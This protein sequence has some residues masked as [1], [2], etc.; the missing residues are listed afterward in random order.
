MI[1]I[2]V[3]LEVISTTSMNAFAA[4]I[5]S[6]GIATV[7]CFFLHTKDAFQ[8]KFLF[9]QGTLVEFGK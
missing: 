2:L 3:N 5:D 4:E 9:E 1:G 7:S 8:V 6:A